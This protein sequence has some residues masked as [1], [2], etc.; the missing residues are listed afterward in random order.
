MHFLVTSVTCILQITWLGFRSFLCLPSTMVIRLLIGSINGDFYCYDYSCS[1]GLDV[2][3]NY[4]SGNICACYPGYNSWDRP[5]DYYGI[6]PLCSWALSIPFYI[7][8]ELGDCLSTPIER[9]S[10]KWDRFSEDAESEDLTPSSW[11]PSILA[12]RV[13]R[14]PKEFATAMAINDLDFNKTCVRPI[15]GVFLQTF[16]ASCSGMNLYFWW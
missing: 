5:T 4:C 13:P 6:C 10:S 3:Y 11:V 9:G 8:E 16:P 12:S 1:G 7:Q 14:T 2:D 15:D